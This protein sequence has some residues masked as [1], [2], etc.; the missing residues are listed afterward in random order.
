V[1]E[2]FSEEHAEYD[3]LA[4]PQEKR[5]CNTMASEENKEDLQVKIEKPATAQLAGRDHATVRTYFGLDWEVGEKVTYYRSDK[6][7][8]SDYVEHDAVIKGWPKKIPDDEAAAKVNIEY[9]PDD[10][11]AMKQSCVMVRSLRAKEERPRSEHPSTVA[12]PV[13]VTL[14]ESD[15]E[16]GASKKKRKTD[17]SLAK[18]VTYNPTFGIPQHGSLEN[19][20]KQAFV[21]LMQ[22]VEK[23]LY[24]PDP[25]MLMQQVKEA[26]GARDKARRQAAAFEQALST[27]RVEREQAQEDAKLNKELL[28]AQRKY[29]EKLVEDIQA[30]KARLAATAE[31]QL[32]KGADPAK[33]SAVLTTLAHKDK[34]IATLKAQLATMEEERDKARVALNSVLGIA[35][36]K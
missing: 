9:D 8:S 19:A 23:G 35:A 11:T 17:G 7:T 3:S 2:T 32:S 28:D 13:D 4:E 12:V 20:T 5:H 24:A 21:V 34:E 6:A 33:S 10:G 27:V 22:A 30:A 25:A 36:K 31:E 1:G 15:D 26:K 16:G 29:N 18:A 14:L